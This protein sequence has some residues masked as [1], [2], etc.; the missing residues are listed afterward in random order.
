MRWLGS[1]TNLMDMN[2]SNL[3][4]IVRERG[5]WC[6]AIHGVTKSRT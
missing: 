3:Q 4:E 6:T 2:L 1:T 5:A